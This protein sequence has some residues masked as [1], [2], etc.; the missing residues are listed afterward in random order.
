MFSLNPTTYEL[1]ILITLGLLLILLILFSR[2]RNKNELLKENSV[3]EAKDK[4]SLQ[5]RVK[6]FEEKYSDV[7]DREE[8]IDKL[9]KEINNK[10]EEI[11]SLRS[12][13]Q[14]KKVIFDGLKAE[15]AIYDETIEFAELGFYKPSF[16]FE[17]SEQYKER[18]SRVKADQKQMVSDK[19]AINCTTE[20]TVE[21]SK[22]KGR[23]MTNKNI[24]MTARAFNNECDAAISKVKWNNAQRMVERIHKAFDAINKL[25]ESNMIFIDNEYLTLKINELKLTHEYHEKKQ[26]EKEEQAEI[27]QQMREEVRLEK[28]MADAFK[29]EDKFQNLLDKATKQ[30][31]KASGDKLSKLEEQIAKLNSDLAD[32][33]QK[34][35]RAKS[36]AE[37]TKVGHVYVISNV[38]SFG[39]DIYKIGMTRRL[40]P[41]DRVKELGDAS[42]PFLFDVHAMIYTENAPELE[43]SLHREFNE[44]R[45]NLVNN[46]KEFFN[47][48]LSD[49]ENI[50]KEKHGDAEFFITAE[51]REFNE[52]KAI[53]AQK[54]EVNDLVIEFPEAI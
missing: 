48:E 10:N 26:Q 14:Q 47:V 46:R 27:R 36:M 15:A 16:S 25:N 49:I 12:S 33:H 8:A 22:V 38:G 5:D 1:V 6:V 41:L 37:Q 42:V 40:E 9:D 39:D 29:E 28:E 7:F 32:A 4:S 51:A 19:T 2:L 17:H 21:G 35:E 34:A 20:W 18:I 13:Y 44:R 30:A 52:S 45:L 24:R 50:V 54:K 31:E 53:R 43:K 3:I 23:T 11:N